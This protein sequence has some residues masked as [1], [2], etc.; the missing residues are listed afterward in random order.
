MEELVASSSLRT[1][2]QGSLYKCQH[3]KRIVI[4]EGLEVIGMDEYPK[5]GYLYYGA[6]EESTVEEV[7]LPS[8]LKRI[9]YSAFRRCTNLKHIS[10]PEGLEKIG[11]SCFTGSGI[12][13]VAI[14]NSVTKL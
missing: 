11:K 9:E 8:T 13:E 6:F 3:L 2:A 4:N 1:I 7:I 14:P 5:E 10:L 12:E